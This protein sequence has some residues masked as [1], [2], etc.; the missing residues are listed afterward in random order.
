[1]HRLKYFIR[2]NLHSSE[3]HTDF[4]T[5]DCISIYLIYIYIYIYI[6]IFFEPY[7]TNLRER[8]RERER[9]KGGLYMVASYR[10][11]LWLIIVV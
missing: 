3:G 9:E 10:M 1:M 4:F 5:G 11:Y 2:Y 8:E 7:T 6:Y